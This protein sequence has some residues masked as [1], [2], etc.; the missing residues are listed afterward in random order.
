MKNLFFIS[1]II[2]LCTFIFISC[3]TNKNETIAPRVSTPAELTSVLNTVYEASDA[4]GFALSVIKDNT[5][6]YQQAFGLADI[7]QNK[8]YTNQTIQP[9]GSISKTFVAAALVK[10]IEQGHFTLETPVNDILPFPLKNPKQPQANIQI[11]HLVTHTSTLLDNFEQYLEA[12]HIL[13]EEDLS[14]D[15]AQLLTNIFGTTQ[16]A[17]KP[18]GNFLAD[19]YLE[20]GAAFSMDNFASTNLGKAWNYS[21]IATSL[22]AY[23]VEVATKT[24]FKEYVAQ[25]ILAPLAMNNTAYDFSDLNTNQIAKLYWD[26]NTS[27]PAYANDSYPDGSLNTSNEDLAKFLM[28]MM[29]GRRG[30]S[31]TLFSKD[32]YDLLFGA[33]LTN[34][35]LPPSVGDNQGVFWILQ[36]GFIRHDGSDPG[37]TCNLWFDQTG[38]VGYLLLTNM[39]ASTTEH[40]IA[41]A[42]LSAKIQSHVNTF[43][44][45]N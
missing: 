42:N 2:L 4:P 39:D 13:P 22:A 18:L 19:Y 15:G 8:T 1:G 7:T 28:D 41:W 5:I 11:K 23:V 40:E 20:D 32:G 35:L 14:T 34:G 44:Q 21:N 31:K 10:A 24:P 37:T 33:L 3:E 26:K 17:T 38:S 27:L 12:Y 16:R 45:A 29:Q 36:D 30:Q 6:I 43:I 9:I 25:N